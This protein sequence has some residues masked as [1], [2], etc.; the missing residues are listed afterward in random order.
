MVGQMK[1]IIQWRSM[2]RFYNF[3]MLAILIFPQY[4]YSADL[5]D[6][7]NRS[8][9]HNNDLKIIMNEHKISKELYNQTSSTIFPSINLSANSNKTEI[10]RYVGSGTN[11]DYTADTYSINVT[12]PIFRLSFFD[13]LE[14]ANDVIEKSNLVVLNQEKVIMVKSVNLYFNLINKKNEISAAVNK[15][16][17]M[18]LKYDNSKKLFQRGLITDAELNRHRNNYDLSLIEYDMAKNNLDLSEQDIYIFAGKKIKEIH[19]LDIEIEIPINN[20]DVGYV[21]SKALIFDENIKMAEYDVSI[22]K[23]DMK[24]NK[25]QH[26]PTLDLIA[27]YDYS[28]VSSG[29]RFGAT[30]REG[31][32]VG[33]SLNIPIYQ[34][35]FQTAKVN[36]ARYVYENAQ[37]NLDQMKR[38]LKKEIIEKINM[39]NLLKKMIIAKKIDYQSANQNYKSAKKGFMSGTYTDVEVQETKLKLIQ[40]KNSYIKTALDYILMDLQLKKFSSTLTE[41]NIKEV[42]AMLVW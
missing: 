35:G 31:S 16:K 22:S 18:S 3:L 1:L 40:A 10:N 27:S 23:N 37:I 9:K 21:V 7:Y 17:M 8:L 38:H 14:K 6:I 24:S 13:E 20:Y 36:E 12:Q 39:H 2:F 28:D 15:E 26:Y 34:G 30:K 33:V 4:S 41:N 19:N 25:S 5:M 29:T 42:N 11:S 32:T